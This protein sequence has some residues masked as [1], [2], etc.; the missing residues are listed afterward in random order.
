M[1]TR[2][3]TRP[4]PARASIETQR[5]QLQRASAVLVGAALVAEHDVDGD[6][7]GDCV[8]TAREL[9][10]AAIVALD[11]VNVSHTQ[12]QEE[13]TMSDTTE[14]TDTVSPALRNLADASDLIAQIDAV[15]DLARVGLDA[16]A[17][18]VADHPTDKI[19]PALE[20]IRD[21]LETSWDSIE[22]LC[23]GRAS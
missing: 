20:L 4:P 12:K 11:S 6:V 18:L 15:N 2:K 10:D 22:E 3:S 1:P 13:P 8:T 14:T 7:V 19:Q 21:R 16:L 9:V 17:Q 5:R 23:A